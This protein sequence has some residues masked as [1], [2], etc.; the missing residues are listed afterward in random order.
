LVFFLGAAAFLALAGF[1]SAAGA[2]GASAGASG[3]ASANG[4]GV[5]A[6]SVAINAALG[7]RRGMRARAS[8]LGCA[9]ERERGEE[10]CAVVGEEVGAEEAVLK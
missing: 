6:T 1:A 7:P 10:S 8:E 3:A 4:A 2:A 9:D 5:S